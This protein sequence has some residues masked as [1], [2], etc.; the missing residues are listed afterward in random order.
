MG[1]DDDYWKM[2]DDELLMKMYDWNAPA[3]QGITLEKLKEVGW[4]RLNVGAPGE[5]VPHAKGNFKTCAFSKQGLLPIEWVIFRNF[6][7]MCVP[8]ETVRDGLQ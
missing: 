1:F 2:S 8:M 3:L 4:M 7:A 6:A 5:R